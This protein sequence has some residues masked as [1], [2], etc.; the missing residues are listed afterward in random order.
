MT[1]LYADDDKEDQEVFS[2]IIH[3]INPQIRLLRADDGLQTIE[4]LSVSD[5]PDII[6][7]DVHMPFLNGYQVLAE[8]RKDDKFRNTQ[9]ILYSTI[10]NHTAL[11]EYAFSKTRCLRKANTINEGMASLR[12]ILQNESVN[13][14]ITPSDVVK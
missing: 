13:I 4:L 14:S 12:E 11:D 2:E 10:A 9:V 7:L 8:I 6:F 3:A 5:V 1:I